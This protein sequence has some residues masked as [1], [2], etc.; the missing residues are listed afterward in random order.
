VHENTSLIDACEVERPP[1]FKER[2]IDELVVER[3]EV[4]WWLV[5]TIIFG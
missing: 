3:E 1:V 5:F 2:Q 4:G